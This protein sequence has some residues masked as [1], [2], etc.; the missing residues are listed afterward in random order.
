MAIIHRATLQ[1]SKLDLL[2]PWLDARPWGGSGEVERVDSYRFDDPDGR[3]G[4]EGLLVRRDGALLHVP[5]TY[6]A[7]RLD[8]APPNTLVGTLEHSVLG[9]RWV[10]DATADP[11]GVACFAR[12]LRGQQA[13]ARLDVWEEGRLLETRPATL[14]LSVV[15]SAPARGG[16]LSVHRELGEPRPPAA[17]GASL[18][19]RWED[20]E[21]VLATLS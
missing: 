10:Y 12:A 14:H 17:D 15:G 13:Q 8:Q 16:A 20:G 18:L 6:R 9:T 19:A 7:A 11:V 3:V 5:L 4:V 2:R 1:P 21:A